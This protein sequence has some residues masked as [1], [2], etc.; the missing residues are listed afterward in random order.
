MTEHEQPHEG[1]SFIRQP[2]GSLKRIEATPPA[3]PKPAPGVITQAVVDGSPQTAVGTADF[4]H[5]RPAGGSGAAPA[6]V[7]QN[8]PEPGTAAPPA[9]PSVNANRDPS[10]PGVLPGTATP[11]V[12]AEP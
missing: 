11:A 6:P 10:D 2:D 9:V 5:T 12:T 3:E 4:G 8:R 7:D 1:G